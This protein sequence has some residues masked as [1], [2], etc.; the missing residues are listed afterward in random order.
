MQIICEFYTLEDVFL[1]TEGSGSLED[2]FLATVGSGS[3]FLIF[4]S[5]FVTSG[6][7][8]SGTLLSI[9]QG[10]VRETDNDH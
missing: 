3:D 1:A 6:I 10:R 9:K 5:T 8:G 7:E 2:V 4:G